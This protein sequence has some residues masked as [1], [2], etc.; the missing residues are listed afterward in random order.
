[1]RIIAGTMRSL[2]LKA[3]KGMN[4]RPTQDRIKETLFNIINP[5]LYDARFLDLFSGSGG[6]GLEAVSRGAKESVFVE[7]DAAAQKCIEE[8]ITF[9]K[10]KDKTKLL[11]QNVLSAI[12]VLDGGEPFDIIFMDPPYHKDLEKKVLKAL[13]DTTLVT[14]DTLI[15]VEASLETSFDDLV[16]MGYEM[17]RYKKYKTNAHAF[18]KQM[19]KD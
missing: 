11:K 12:N 1:M 14:P 15:I 9:T 3:P 19:G 10:C 6:I 2:P 18:I 4:T 17:T 7:Q 8:N 5:Y 13:K 16:E